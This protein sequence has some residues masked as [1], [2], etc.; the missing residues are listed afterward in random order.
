LAWLRSATNINSYASTTVCYRATA[1]QTEKEAHV[2][3]C[4]KM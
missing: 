4:S 2:A 3:K 1:A